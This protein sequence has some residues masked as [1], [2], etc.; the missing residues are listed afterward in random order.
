M[1]LA[2]SVGCEW[3]VSGDTLSQWAASHCAAPKAASGGQSGHLPG[4]R[5]GGCSIYWSRRVKRRSRARPPYRSPGR[6]E[7]PDAH[8]NCRRDSCTLGWTYFVVGKP[9]RP[10]PR[11]R[12]RCPRL[13]LNTV[14]SGA[15]QG[16]PP[17]ALPP[18][19]RIS[20]LSTSGTAATST[21]NAAAAA[22]PRL[23]SWLVSATAATSGMSHGVRGAARRMCSQRSGGSRGC[24][25]RVR[26]GTVSATGKG[27]VPSRRPRAPAD[28]GAGR[29]DGFACPV[30]CRR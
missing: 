24:A 9:A 1:L 21:W 17:T 4:T 27:F 23:C 12:R 10:A 19:K 30:D 15:A 3:A 11:G 29:G 6:P 2:Y 16:T 5:D 13:L 26:P 14:P 7:G 20:M 25:V 18:R 22:P 28:H 8:R